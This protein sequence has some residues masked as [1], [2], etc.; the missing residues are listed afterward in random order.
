M[1]R[2]THKKGS[3]GLSQVVANEKSCTRRRGD[4][5]RLPAPRLPDVLV[6]LA[7]KELTRKVNGPVRVP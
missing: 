7:T 1:N 3:V 4:L 5:K 2:W 6:P